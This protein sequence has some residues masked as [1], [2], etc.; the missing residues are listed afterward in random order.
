MSD[1]HRISAA[2]RSFGDL[3]GD[4]TDLFGKELRLAQSELKHG[5]ANLTQAAMLFVVMGVVALIAV[6]LLL[7]G[8]VHFIASFGLALHWSYMLVALALLVV[9]GIIFYVA[10]AKASADNLIPKRTLVQ[11][12]ETART[13]KEQIR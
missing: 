10:R 3:F 5:L 13:L 9:A 2:V 8:I 6:M 11:L 1:F 4:L 7:V 12:G